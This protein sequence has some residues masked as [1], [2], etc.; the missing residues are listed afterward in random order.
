MTGFFYCCNENE[1][2]VSVKTNK[3]IEKTIIV[4]ARILKVPA[5]TL[6]TT[7]LVTKKILMISIVKIRNSAVTMTTNKADTNKVMDGNPCKIY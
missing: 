4:S 5:I 1:G 2:D 6:L 3:S 7:M